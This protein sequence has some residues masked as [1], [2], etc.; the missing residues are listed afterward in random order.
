MTRTSHRQKWDESISSRE[1]QVPGKTVYCLTCLSEMNTC[2]SQRYYVPFAANI[3]F[4]RTLQELWICRVCPIWWNLNV[5]SVLIFKLCKETRLLARLHCQTLLS[6]WLAFFFFGNNIHK[7]SCKGYMSIF[8][9]NNPL[10]VMAK[11]KLIESLRSIKRTTTRYNGL[12][13]RLLLTGSIESR[14]NN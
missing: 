1:C 10:L 2:T 8:Y 4:C 13:I 6:D 14:F 11:I 7:M 12:K 3:K 5:S 9:I